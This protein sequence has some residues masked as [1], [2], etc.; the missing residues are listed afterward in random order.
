[1]TV[2]RKKVI[3]LA[4]LVLFALWPICQIALTKTYDVNP[5]KLVAWGMYSVPQIN[6]AVGLIEIKGFP[7]GETPIMPDRMPEEL[8]RAI[9][10]FGR[11]RT[12]LGELASPDKLAALALESFPDVDQIRVVIHRAAVDR[13]S[14]VVMI[15]KTVREYSR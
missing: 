8:V 11:R 9:G 12:V 7:G 6:V 5:W 10:E 13:R 2:K 15:E 14:A 1:M 3:L 4:W